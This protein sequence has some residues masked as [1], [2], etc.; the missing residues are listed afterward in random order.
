MVSKQIGLPVVIKPFDANQGKGV[1]LNLKNKNEII[2]AFK[3][4][5]KYSNGIIVEQYISGRDYRVL[6][7]GGKVC[8]VAERLPALVIGDGEHTIEELVK[9]INEDPRRGE[10]HEKALT[11]IRLDAVADKLLKLNNMTRESV[12]S[13]G[14]IVK[15]R[16]NANLSTGGTAVDCTDLIHPDNAD[17]AVRAANAIGIDIAGIDIVTEDI[18]K[19]V[20]DTGGAVVEVNTA[21]GIRMH[22]YPSKGTPRNVA[23]DIVRLLFPDDSA[24]NFPLFR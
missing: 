7:V 2:A 13:V 12:P 17:I 11:K 21:P 14:E 10:Q 6:V 3:D 9:I 16:G 4:A 23:E 5:S 18:S 19:S 24:A 8:A 1:H 20:Y 15:L 22:L